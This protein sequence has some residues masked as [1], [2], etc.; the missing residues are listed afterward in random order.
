MLISLSA[1]TQTNRTVYLDN[2]VL[3]A[4]GLCKYFESNVIGELSSGYT[5]TIS[6]KET[7]RGTLIYLSAS[8]EDFLFRDKEIEGYLWFSNHI[9]LLYNTKF[10][11]GI[12]KMKHP[13]L[14]YEYVYYPP[15]IPYPCPVDGGKEWVFLFKDN[16]YYLIRENIYW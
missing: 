10:I 11:P 3:L 14:K 13:I 12:K 1:K 7:E 4:P 15:D 6:A 2:Y 16:E 8:K 9:F 5:C